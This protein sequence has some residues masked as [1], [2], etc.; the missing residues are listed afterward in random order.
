MPTPT[1]QITL[2]FTLLDYDGNQ[3]GNATQPAWLRIALC[4]YGSNL[5]RV[6]GAGVI[7]KTAS[8]F[9]DIPYLGVAGTIKLWGNDVIVPETTYYQ[10]SVL[11]TN[12]NVIQT[13]LY[14]FTGT[15]TVDLSSA[16][17][18]NPPNPPG[19]ASLQYLPCAGLVPGTVY[20]APGPVI[21]VA[22]NGVL[23]PGGK[24]FPIL[25]YTLGGETVINLNF[26]TETEDLIYAL[27]IAD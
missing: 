15:E 27:C 24:A 21:A 1:P 8:W 7:G 2:N 14:L 18:I 5:P 13:G 22:Y 16:T 26:S 3:I 4:N 19:L 12:K 20:T 17:P 25:S 11:D 6:P 10:I 23:L 9:I